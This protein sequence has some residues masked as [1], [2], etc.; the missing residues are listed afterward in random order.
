MRVVWYNEIMDRGAV[1]LNATEL[2]NIE[3]IRRECL[4]ALS[5]RL[6]YTG[7]VTFIRLFDSGNGDYS[8][9]RRELVDETTKEDI[10]SFL[11]GEDKIRQADS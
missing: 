2:K 8:K 11:R 9:E 10:L 7:M 3:I 6:G 4:D 5:K 1:M